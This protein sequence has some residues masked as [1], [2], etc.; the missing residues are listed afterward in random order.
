[1]EYKCKCYLLCKNYRSNIEKKFGKD[2][3]RLTSMSMKVV[4][5]Y[6]FVVYT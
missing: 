1:M 5:V 3:A 2:G 6:L 4:R